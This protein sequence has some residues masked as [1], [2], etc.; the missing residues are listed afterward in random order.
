[1]AKSYFDWGKLSKGDAYSYKGKVKQ[2]GSFDINFSVK[3]RESVFAHFDLYNFKDDLDLFLYRDDG[4]KSRRPYYEIARSESDGKKTEAIFKG[5]TP[6][7]YILEIEHFENLGRK[8]KDS[9][10]TVGRPVKAC[11]G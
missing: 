6:G 1:M 8:H 4:S 2:G 11:C 10:F 5:L 9:K 7:N 3:G